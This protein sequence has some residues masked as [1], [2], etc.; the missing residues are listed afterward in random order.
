MSWQPWSAASS[1][2]SSVLLPWLRSTCT[3]CK[4]QVSGH[5]QQQ[6]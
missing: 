5:Q 6:Q 1:R 4:A 3:S 2:T